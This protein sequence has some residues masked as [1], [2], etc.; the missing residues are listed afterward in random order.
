MNQEKGHDS[1]QW[2]AERAPALVDDPEPGKIFR[3]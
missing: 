3:P 1:R 2:L